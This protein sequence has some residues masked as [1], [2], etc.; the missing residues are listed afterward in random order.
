M[1]GKVYYV[2]TNKRDSVQAIS[3]KL[4]TLIGESK[5][6]SFIGKDDFTAIKMHFG[7]K[8]N[9]GH[10]R[11][12]W[13]REAVK[14]VKSLTANAFLSDSNVIYKASSRTNSIDHLRIA[15]EHGFNPENIGV[16][17]LIADGL[18]GRNFVEVPV[19][20]RHFS[21]IKMAAD[22]AD[23]D[24]LLAMTHITGHILTGMGGAIKNVGMGCASRR[25]KY[26][27]HCGAVPEV[28]A[29][30]C[31]GCGECVGICPAGALSL[32][33]KKVAIAKDACLGCGECAVVCKTKAIE[34][35]WS[36][37]LENLQEKM[38]E[39]A[40]G[41]IDSFGSNVGYINFLIKVTRD[42]DCLAKDDPRIADDLGILASRD[43]V[44]I[45]KA[46]VDL[47]KASSG[48]DIFAAGYPETDWSVQ[49]NYAD[50]MGLGSL[51]YKLEEVR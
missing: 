14:H 6:L 47:I 26:E 40:K 20:G 25:G 16:P 19:K 43:P 9:T 44:A 10:I 24:G 39:Y 28:D 35:R 33:N 51:E 4:G 41:V 42:C 46:S 11:S 31:A 30:H 27:Q 29:S 22:F 15:S 23:C 18:R 34:I 38:V 2:K 3:K 5:V 21:K 8:G 13:I 50:K 1:A 37:T 48:K 32:K 17:V 36:E 49:L 7:D 45:D 12:E